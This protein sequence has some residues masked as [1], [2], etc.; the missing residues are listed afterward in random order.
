[1]QILLLILAAFTGKNV[2]DIIFI[3]LNAL[4]LI[5]LDFI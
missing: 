5:V 3:L 1:L 2:F 4:N